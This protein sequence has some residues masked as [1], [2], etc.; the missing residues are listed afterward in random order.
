MKRRQ[1]KKRSKVREDSA[2]YGSSEASPFGHPKFIDLFCGIGG[3][4]I[5]F[6]KAGAQCVFSSDYDTFSQQTYAANFGEKPHGDIHEAQSEKI[7]QKSA[8][9]CLTMRPATL[10]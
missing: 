2:S 8:K 9:S 6:E 4:R 1:S 5:A 10:C 7:L 3:F